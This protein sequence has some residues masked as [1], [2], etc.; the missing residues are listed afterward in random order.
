M[1]DVPKLV[2]KD[3]TLELG[4]PTAPEDDPIILKCPWTVEVNH[5]FAALLTI[6]RDEAEKQFYY[7]VPEDRAR[8]LQEVLFASVAS[9]NIT[10]DGQ[11]VKGDPRTVL[12]QRLSPE[13]L[14]LL[15]RQFAQ[16][17][18]RLRDQGN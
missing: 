15:R 7:R 18:L 13:E 14:L 5:D 8:D 6:G 3:I 17:A 4:P 1:P 11:P 9:H 2:G 10:E 16:K 12:L